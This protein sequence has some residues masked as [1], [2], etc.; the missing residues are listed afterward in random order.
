MV[1][2]TPG[3]RELQLWAEDDDLNYV[4]Q[5]IVDLIAKCKFSN[6]THRSEPGCAVKVALESGVLSQERFTRYLTQQKELK[7]LEAK[8]KQYEQKSKK[9]INLK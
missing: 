4:Y 9:S 1:I 2:D 8:K 3:M 6:C 5:D 7:R